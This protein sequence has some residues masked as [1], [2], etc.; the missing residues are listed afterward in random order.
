MIK[1]KNTKSLSNWIFCVIVRVWFVQFYLNKA[2]IFNS[3]RTLS[4]AFF[5]SLTKKVAIDFTLAFHW[6]RGWRTFS[7]PIIE[8]DEAKPIKSGSTFHTRLKNRYF[9]CFT[10]LENY[11][12]AV[13]LARSMGSGPL[14]FKSD[15]QSPPS[16]YSNTIQRCFFVSKLHHIPTTNGFSAKVRMSLS[17]NTCCTWFL[18]S[19]SCLFIFFIANLIWVCLC[20]TR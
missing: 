5:A 9:F 1:K 2:S 18:C 16:T 12:K 4:F 3:L 13:Y 20:R 6:L 17:A 7:R 10:V 11:W 15:A 14:F 19:I 8:P